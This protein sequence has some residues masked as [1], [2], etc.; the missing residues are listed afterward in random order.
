MEILRFGPLVEENRLEHLFLWPDPRSTVQRQVR[1]LL[2]AAD[3]Q[4]LQPTQLRQQSAA[5]Q[6][7]PALE[8]A[9]YADEA[10]RLI[11]AGDAAGRYR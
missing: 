11:T 7:L 8:Y 3:P 6:G 2:T 10:P 4:V 9:L 1:A 5:V